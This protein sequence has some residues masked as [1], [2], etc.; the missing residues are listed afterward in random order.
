MRLVP[1]TVIAIVFSSAAVFG[2]TAPSPLSRFDVAASIGSFSRNQ[3]ELSEWGEWANSLFRG[4]SGGIYWTDNLKT[5]LDIAWSGEGEAYGT[6]AVQVSGVSFTQLYVEHRYRS[7]NISAGQVYQFRRNALFHPFV[8]GGVDIDRERHEIER[9]P[10]PVYFGP[11]P[12]PRTLALPAQIRTETNVRVRP[13]AA[14]G[15]KAY[16]SERGFFRTE[17]KM[18]FTERVDQVVW[19]LGVGVDF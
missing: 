15:F 13:F 11:G 14:T 1:L 16:F 19:K 2:Q 7:F 4:F 6:E 10:Q 5:E 9:P 3:A 8:T 18:N 17:L 12:P